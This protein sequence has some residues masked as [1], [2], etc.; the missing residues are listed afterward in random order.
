MNHNRAERIVCRSRSMGS[1]HEL[2]YNETKIRH[3]QVTNCKSQIVT[4]KKNVTENS[5][6]IYLTHNARR[7]SITQTHHWKQNTKTICETV[8]FCMVM[9][10]CNPPNAKMKQIMIM[11]RIKEA[12]DSGITNCERCIVGCWMRG[13]VD[14]EEIE[15]SGEKGHRVWRR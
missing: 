15:Y 2:W 3:V 14:W 5:S 9:E 12:L 8:L 11:R 6:Q 7:R 13:G 4:W 10:G 1:C